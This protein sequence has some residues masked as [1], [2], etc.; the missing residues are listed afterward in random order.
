[1]NIDKAIA[2]IDDAIG[3]LKLTRTEHY[4]LQVA[5]DLVKVMWQEFK[6]L[7]E[8][9]MKAQEVAKDAAVPDEE[10]TPID[11]NAGTPVS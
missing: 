8:E 7:K 1:M 5:M 6:R 2:I 4:N 3:Q 9:E 10:K 11:K